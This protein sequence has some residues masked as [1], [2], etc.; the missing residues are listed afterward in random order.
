MTSM[1]ITANHV[2]SDLSNIPLKKDISEAHAGPNRAFD[3]ISDALAWPVS[4]L[5][6]ASDIP[7]V[8]NLGWNF[9]ELAN[10]NSAIFELI[11]PVTKLLTQWKLY[12]VENLNLITT[13]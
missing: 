1:S 10:A 5:G 12:T 4:G 3:L 2:W 11:Q 13:I 6:F 7:T 8:A 9:K